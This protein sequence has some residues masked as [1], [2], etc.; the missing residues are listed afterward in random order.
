MVLSFGVMPLI[1]RISSKFKKELR[2]Y[3]WF[4]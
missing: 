2:S 1:M 4:R 3:D